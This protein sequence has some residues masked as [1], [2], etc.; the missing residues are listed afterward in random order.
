MLAV[1]LLGVTA[2]SAFGAGIQ[3][4]VKATQQLAVLVSAHGAH[5]EPEAGSPQTE[6]VP[7]RRPITGERTT[8]PVTGSLTG[9][10]GVRWLQVM[11][12]GRPNSSTG[13]IAQQGTRKLMTG[14]HIVV[15]LAARRVSAYSNGHLLRSFRA[16]VGKSSTPTPTGQFFVEEIVQMAS[17]EAGGP[18]ALALSA[19]SDAL[20]EFEGGPGQIAIHGRDN[21][22]GTLGAAES[23]GCIRLGSA[24]ID[25]LAARIG[26]G[27][28]ATIYG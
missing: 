4:R 28:P 15:D 7:S 5:Q 27:T 8:L 20:Q 23:H 26:P 25:W 13:W 19:R 12:P 18:F 2:G 6:V 1:C 21:L 24:G 17:G 14:W 10:D 9:A 16:V 22:G 11:L 3:P